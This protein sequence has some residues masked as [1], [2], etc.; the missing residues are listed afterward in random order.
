V[1]LLLMP[2]GVPGIPAPPPGGG[3]V[4]APTSHIDI[5]PTLLDAAGV[6]PA[7]PSLRLRGASLLPYLTGAAA[8]DGP[9][10][11]GKPALAALQFHSNLGP[12]SA[13]GIVQLVNAT[14]GGAAAAAAAAA[15]AP[16]P[17]PRILKL[18]TYGRSLLL[19][20]GGP[21]PPQLYDLTADPDELT[22]LAPSRPDLVA[23]LN[24]S[25]EAEFGGPGALAAI[26]ASQIAINVDLYARWFHAQCAPDAL[27]AALDKAYKGV[28]RDELVQRVT[29]WTGLDPRNA[30]GG[31]P[32]TRCPNNGASLSDD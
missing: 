3:V 32:G 16:P 19:P 23:A 2:V 9:L 12:G 18:I 8:P 25:L 30:T 27:L 15:T 13:F 6:T 5:L 26:D 20:G 24:A 29:D 11:G 21:V 17:S 14:P 28:P 4:T 7:P 22:N 31:G 1:P 10:P